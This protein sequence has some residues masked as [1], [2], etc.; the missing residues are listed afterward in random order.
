MK[1]GGKQCSCEREGNMT[2][3]C[4]GKISKKMNFRGPCRKECITLL[5]KAE[6]RTAEETFARVD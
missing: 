4:V 3:F 5:N 2:G 6:E 1:I